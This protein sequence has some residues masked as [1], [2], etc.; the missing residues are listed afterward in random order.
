MT[1][2]FTLAQHAAAGRDIRLDVR[3]VEGYRAFMNKMWNATRFAL[4][5]LEDWSPSPLDAG[6]DDFS[7]ADRWILTRLAEVTDATQL[8][9]EEYRFSD[10]A[11]GLYEFFWGSLCDWY[12]EL[13][14]PVLYGGDSG[15]AVVETE[16]GAELEGVFPDTNVPVEDVIVVD[17]DESATLFAAR[18][19]NGDIIEVQPGAILEVTAEG[20]VAV[21]AYG[22]PVGDEVELVIMSTPTL[23]GTY[24]VDESGSI[25]TRANMP[26]TIG[27]G[28]H[29][30][31]VASPNVQAAL[32]LKIA[33]T[34]APV[35]TTLPATGSNAATPIVIV[36]LALGSLLA[37][38]TRRRR[39][40]T[41][42]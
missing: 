35:A 26:D 36:L 19:Q 41:G 5:H 21:L 16:T 40:L 7:A 30:L 2:R 29:T 1:L 8:A 17:I 37:L 38:T 6:R 32:G 39:D 18:D 11:Q 22:L 28:D 13:A 4:M 12:L 27:S 42:L 14:K 10:A 34:T 20:E 33:D 31:V 23:L 24:I 3:R 25:E 15:I 9:L